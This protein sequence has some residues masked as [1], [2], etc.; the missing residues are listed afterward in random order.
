MISLILKSLNGRVGWL[1]M[2]VKWMI[3]K[4]LTNYVIQVVSHVTTLLSRAIK[5]DGT[6]DGKVIHTVQWDNLNSIFIA[7]QKLYQITRVQQLL[8]D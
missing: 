7:S 1:T 5:L 6:M 3:R 8:R 2:Q 4:Q